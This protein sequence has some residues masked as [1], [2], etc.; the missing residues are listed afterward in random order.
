MLL[1]L[2][3]GRPNNLM[4]RNNVDRKCYKK[5]RKILGQKKTKK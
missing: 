2:L 4:S 3:A 5:I 1:L